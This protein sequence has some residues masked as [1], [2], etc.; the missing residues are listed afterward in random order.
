M[1]MSLGKLYIVAT[2]IGNIKDI[3]FRA[4][5]VLKT[6]DLILSEDTRETDKLLRGYSI[7]TPQIPY[8]DQKHQ[9][10]IDKIK[11][12]LLNG[13]NIAL[14]TDN[15][16]PVISDPGY[17]L[18]VELRIS[19][20]EVQ[21]IPGPSVVTAVIPISGLPSDKFVFLGFLPK[22]KSKREAILK[23]YGK[24]DAT[25]TIFESPYRVRRLLQE[26]FSVLGNRVVFI[27]KDI[28]KQKEEVLYSTLEKLAKNP[29]SIKEK[30][31]YTV[32][33]AKK[34]FGING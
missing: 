7:T 30:G 29:A 17:K 33:I 9:K 11:S 12:D 24:L 20:F 10:I 19:G 34:G 31:E 3:T 14:V 26:A 4:I 18:M 32:L 27:A 8:T 16:T 13:L 2:P 21:T 1:E 28:T 22:T 15:G 5:E 6:V 25:L 23:Q